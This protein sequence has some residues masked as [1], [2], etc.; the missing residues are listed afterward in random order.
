MICNNCNFDY[1]DELI[2]IVRCCGNV[3][4]FLCGGR[5]HSHYSRSQKEEKTGSA[6]SLAAE[7]KEAPDVTSEE[8]PI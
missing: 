4:V 3:T 8:N 7:S 6:A 1:P 2:Q 5:A